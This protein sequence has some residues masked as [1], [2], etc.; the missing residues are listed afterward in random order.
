MVHTGFSYTVGVEREDSTLCSNIRIVHYRRIL[1]VHP[2]YINF[3]YIWTLDTDPF[4]IIHP[5]ASGVCQHT[6][7]N[8]Q[9][10]HPPKLTLP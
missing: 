1:L 10:R 9:S 2:V 3:L 5:G 7:D 4:Y 6:L 8:L